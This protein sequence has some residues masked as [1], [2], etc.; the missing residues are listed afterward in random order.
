MAY[1]T[2]LL[3]GWIQNQ[4]A[5]QWI[6]LGVVFVA[7]L[8]LVL[9]IASLFEDF[10]NPVR[11]RFK[12]ITQ[13]GVSSASEP[14]AVT[15]LL[16][17]RQILYM[18]LNKE[19]L[20]RTTTRLH[21]AG[22]HS[23]N[24]LYV[25][26]GLKMSF[27][28]LLPILVVLGMSFFIGL[29]AVDFFRGGVIAL[30]IGYLGPSLILDRLVANRK[31][32]LQRSFPDA[33]DMIVICCEVGLSLDAAIQKVSTEFIINHPELAAELNMVMA[34]TRLG[35]DRMVALKRIVERTGVESIG[36][37]VSTLSQSM[38]YGTS[39]GDS[40]RL[41]AEDFR[42]RRAQAAE[43]TAAKIGLKLIFP[44]G[45]CLLPAFLMVLLAPTMIV[46]QNLK[47]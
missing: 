11:N 37:L 47:N 39:I 38:R 2:Q 21:H 19:L 3:S 35:V 9:A 12:V 24:S 36:G 10:F 46:L 31:K 13:A 4:Q 7:F 14:S 40:L 34:E 18:P 45:I 25:Y 15:E 5:N 28:V 32:V 23:A 26:Y 30:A 33:L 41:Y 22:F 42:D 8:L 43:E 16:R 17:K 27:T 29:H 20:Q 1:F 44:L 6:V